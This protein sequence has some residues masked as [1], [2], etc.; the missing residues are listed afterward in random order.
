MSLRILDLNWQVRMCFKVRSRRRVLIE[1][2]AYSI[3]L[4]EYF[5][6]QLEDG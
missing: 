5:R 2:E 3:F 4:T 1:I 6:F